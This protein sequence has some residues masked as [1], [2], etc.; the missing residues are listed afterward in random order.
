MEILM[1]LM[2]TVN[3]RKKSCIDNLITPN[4]LGNVGETAEI[5]TDVYSDIY[6]AP[7]I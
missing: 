4:L 5:P 1:I 7:I 6:W 3:H 2:Q